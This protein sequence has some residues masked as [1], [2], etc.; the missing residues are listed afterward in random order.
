MREVLLEEL[1]EEGAVHVPGVGR[2]SLSLKGNLD[3]S[4]RLVTQTARLKVNFRPERD[5]TQ[6]VN[7]DQSFQYVGA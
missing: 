4:E 6:E 5:L 2:F 3:E 7:Q 1:R